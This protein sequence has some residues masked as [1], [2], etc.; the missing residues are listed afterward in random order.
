MAF[1]DGN[2]RSPPHQKMLKPLPLL[3]FPL[4]LAGCGVP[5]YV[6]A[7]RAPETVVQVSE[8]QPANLGQAI[9]LARDRLYEFTQAA[10][11]GGSQ[12]VRQARVLADT[13][14][15]T[16][17]VWIDSVDYEDGSFVGIV[18]DVP[19][20][21]DIPVGI[22]ISVPTEDVTDWVIV[23]DTGM[24]GGFTLP[25]TGELGY[26]EPDALMPTREE[27]RLESVPES[28]IPLEG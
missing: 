19:D 20:D 9:D 12:T 28:D 16:H 17:T 4:S 8:Q 23:S 24:V 26:G 2:P 6:P 11:I 25:F 5:E 3:L 10:M 13:E 15:G 27:D 14:D 1:L 21:A 22:E 18:A 7:E